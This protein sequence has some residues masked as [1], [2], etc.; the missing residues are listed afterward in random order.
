[1]TEHSHADEQALEACAVALRNVHAFLHGALPEAEA[2][3]I[4]AHL[5]ACEACLDDFDIEQT[6]TVMIK[7]CQP[8]VQASPALRE[9]IA[10]MTRVS[11]TS[12]E[13]TTD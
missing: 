4:R 2:D 9:R 8:E 13:W 11:F 1:M 10:A 6:I 5:M 3:E 12:V 7:R